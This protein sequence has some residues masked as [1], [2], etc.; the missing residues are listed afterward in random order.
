MKNLRW[1]VPFT[2][3]SMLLVGCGGGSS[4]EGAA[5][6]LPPSETTA[7]TSKPPSNSNAGTSEANVPQ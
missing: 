7:D 5:T 6:N 4:D 2:L 3:F 1:I